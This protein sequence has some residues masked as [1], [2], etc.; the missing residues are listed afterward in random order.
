MSIKKNRHKRASLAQAEGLATVAES[1]LSAVVV[2]SGI[3]TAPLSE[4][5][6][7]H[8]SAALNVFA[9]SVGDIADKYK[10]S[11]GHALDLSHVEAAFVTLPAI[12]NPNV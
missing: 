4:A 2:L 10:K 3:D 12:E 9:Y 11:T 6:R 1:Y 8:V 7:Q 5:A